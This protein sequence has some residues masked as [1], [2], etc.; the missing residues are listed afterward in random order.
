MDLLMG[1]LPVRAGRMLAVS[2]LALAVTACSS[3]YGTNGN[4]NGGISLGSGGS[5]ND[6]ISPDFAIAYVKRTLPSPADPNAQ[7]TTD[8]RVQRIWNGPADVWV[9]ERASPT[10]G[11]RNI[12]FRVTQGQW[13]VR[14]LDTS[15]D[16]TRLIFSMRQKPTPGLPE[17]QQPTWTIYEYVL[18]TDTLRELIT[19]PIAAHL[20]HDVGPHYLP[21]GRIVFS[22]TRQRGAKEML[23]AEGKGQFSAV[24]EGDGARTTQAFVLHLMNADGSGIRQISYNTGHDLD[25][26]V[27]NDGRIVFTRWDINSGAGMH[28]YAMN[29][30]GGN[31][32]LLYGRNSHDT[33]TPSSANGGPL[34]QFTQARARPDGKLVAVTLPFQGTDFGGDVVLIDA[35]NWVENLQTVPTRPAPMPL[36]APGMG[37]SRLVVNDVRTSQAAAVPAGTLQAP[38]PASPGG[39]FAS[40]YPLW[41]GTNRLLVGWTQCRLVDQGQIVPCTPSNLAKAG[42]VPAPTIYSIWIYDTSNDTSLPIVPP[43]EGVMYTD[44]VAFMPRT[45]TPLT[46]AAVGQPPSFTQTLAAEQVGILNIKS[47]Y[48]F[49]GVPQAPGIIGIQADPTLRQLTGSTPRFVRI[50]KAVSLPDTETLA[51]NLLPAYA[52]GPAGDYMR[53]II[54]YAPVEPDGSVRVTVPSNI[55]FEIS[56]LDANGRRISEGVFP[57]HRAWLQIRTGETVTCNGCHVQQA[58]P[59]SNSHGR[60][61]LFPLLNTGAA[62]T[63]QAFAHTSLQVTDA[64]GNVGP[65]KRGPNQYETMAEYRAQVQANCFDDPNP[66]AGLPA[67][68]I[69]FHDVWTIPATAAVP[70]PDISWSYATIGTPPVRADCSSNWIFN[71]RIVIHYPA[72]IATLWTTPRS[73]ITAVNPATNTPY[74]ACTDCHSPADAAGVR[75]VS[76]GQLDLTSAPATTTPCVQQQYNSFCQLL[77]P[78]PQLNLVTMQPVVQ[79]VVDPV[80]GQITQVIVQWP[81]SMSGAGANASPT[82]FNKFVPGTSP[83]SCDLGGAPGSCPHP[84]WLTGE[85]LKLI[86]EWL[87][88]GAQYYNNPF[89]VPPPP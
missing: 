26:S 25:P 10:A 61:G 84:G 11:A 50:E 41:D 1:R 70:E 20:G 43:T 14:D 17:S 7:L 45:V 32:G 2:L 51:A 23:V 27:L 47:V 62:V 60:A 80:T 24:I 21:D 78:H 34:I 54:G 46:D 88:I 16:G 4:P 38:P 71:C 74:T 42:V 79:Q 33:G 39:R 57:R 36:P 19:D 6:P 69:L 63:G 3:T 22:S 55:P 31:F 65:A 81:A 75:R 83:T 76:A 56:V 53:E 18:A 67:V 13:D 8:L 87:D 68:D 29:P 77:Y 44:A 85:E 5:S 66:C 37:Q 48:D 59:P 73:S 89:A 52:F 64:S 40:A 58:T 35:G 30:D 72:H 82:F 49:D 28:L 12:T 86:S 9:R 15:F